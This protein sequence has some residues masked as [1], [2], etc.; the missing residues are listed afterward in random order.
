MPQRVVRRL[1]CSGILS[2]A[3]CV[4]ARD[5]TGAERAQRFKDAACVPARSARFSM[6]AAAIL[7]YSDT[8]VQVARSPLAYT[9]RFYARCCRH[10]LIDEARLR[11]R[12]APAA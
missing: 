1:I 2:R 4:R 9:P 10:D 12:T 6:R 8:H 5:S 7:L 11:L 3:C